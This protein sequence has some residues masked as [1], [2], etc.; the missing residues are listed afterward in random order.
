MS[1][2]LRAIIATVF[3]CMPAIIASMTYTAMH[4]RR[5]KNGRIDDAQHAAVARSLGD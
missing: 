4:R 1:Y 5:V 2:I 3:C